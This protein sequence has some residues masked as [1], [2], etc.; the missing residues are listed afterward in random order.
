MRVLLDTCVL[1][2]LRRPRPHP[3][4]RRTV[5]GL[6]SSDLFISV[7]S[8]GEIAKGIAL[9]AD[10]LHKRALHVW[11]QTL[12]RNY[13][14]RILPVDLETSRIWGEVA[15]ATQ[16]AGRPIG[17]IDAL[18]AATARRHGLVVMTRNIA[19]FEPS[20]VSVLNP[21]DQ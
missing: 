21:W 4:V 10:S 8:I 1:S 18:I 7:I 19:D 15:A 3:I 5:E 2:E 20:G 9:L 17:A 16:K 6:D 12:E 14:D 13:S 11:L